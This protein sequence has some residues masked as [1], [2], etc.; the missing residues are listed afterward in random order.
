M[1]Y[2]GKIMVTRA[3]AAK[4]ERLCREPDAK[5]SRKEL[6]FDKGY[7]FPNGYWM[8][9]QVCPSSDPAREPCWTQGVLFTPVGYEAGCSEV[10][11][12]FVGE[13][14]AVDEDDEDTK[15]A[16]KIVIRD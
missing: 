1:T 10:G 2:K 4:L 13:Y 8:A 12:K 7:T 3:L 6:P 16:V 15:Y 14:V 9:I 11:Y 5:I